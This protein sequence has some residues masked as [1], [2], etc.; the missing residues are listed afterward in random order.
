LEALQ[1]MSLT[2]PVLCLGMDD[3]F[4][5][6]GDPASLMKQIGLTAAGIQQALLARWPALAQPEQSTV[7][8]LKKAS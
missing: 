7:V 8:P 4:I 1:A 5:E 6:H 2:T 3:V